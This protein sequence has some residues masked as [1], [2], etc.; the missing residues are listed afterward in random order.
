MEPVNPLRPIS[1]LDPLSNAWERTQLLLFEPFRLGR[2][3]TVA[4]CAW[5]ATIGSHEVSSA[6]NAGMGKILKDG[7]ARDVVQQFDQWLRNNAEA[8]LASMAI[9][10]VAAVISGLLILWL[11]SRG[12][13]MFL[14]CVA[15][16]NGT[17]AS[18]WREYAAE[19]NSLFGFR[20]CAHAISALPVI[21]LIGVMGFTS[22]RM[23]R[24]QTVGWLD[25]GVIV[26]CVVG[27][28][29]CML[30]FVVI[31]KL[32]RDFVVPIMYRRRIGTL[33]AWRALGG[34]MKRRLGPIVIYL[35]FQIVM[36]AVLATVKLGILI[37]TCC[38]A[39][40]PYIGAV[41]LLPLLVFERAYSVC[42]L[43]QF[44]E[45]WRV[46]E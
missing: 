14:C 41:I 25:V 23:L 1:V 21:P 35:L 17:V 24:E 43:E 6:V 15:R 30:T 11:S 26:G 45:D 22:Y 4:F 3:L 8:L 36:Q 12:R 29:L 19:G 28:T 9:A 44:G 20:L 13:F 40:F 32:T 38:A 34:L 7:A 27:A 16:N 31:E 2:W 18:S 5:L 39:G 10:A 42:Y 33:A 37:I 46:M